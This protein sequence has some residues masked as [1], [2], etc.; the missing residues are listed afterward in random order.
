MS[1]PII[2]AFDF[3]G[4][5]SRHDSLRD[6]LRFAMTT[7]RFIR[8]AIRLTPTLLAFKTGRIHNDVAKERA[9]AL[10]FG[11]MRIAD[12][13]RLAEAFAL[14]ALPRII[15]PKALERIR[16]HVNQGHRVILVSASLETYLKPWALQLGFSDVCG[17]RL[18]VDETGRITGK[19]AGEN[20]WGPEKVRRLEALLGKL[21]QYEIYAYGDTRGDQEMLS[22]AGH[23]HFRP[24]E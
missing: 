11:G 17:S 14:H 3:D 15:R 8:L 5:I 23:P 16:W 13:E 6:L 9:L 19:L 21:N 20:C 2:A 12:F 24:F 18:S 10:A 1:K 7:P 4:T 22:I